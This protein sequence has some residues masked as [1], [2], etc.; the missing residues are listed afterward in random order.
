MSCVR[1]CLNLT[2]FYIPIYLVRLD[3]RVRFACLRHRRLVI[4]AGE[5]LEIVIYPD[6][7][8]RFET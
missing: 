5:E 3:E 6:G 8:W 1:V 4:L 2:G 7:E